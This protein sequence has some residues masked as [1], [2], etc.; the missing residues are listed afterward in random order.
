MSQDRER[1]AILPGRHEELQRLANE[2]AALRRVATLV[3]HE[4]PPAEVFAAVTEE[5]GRLLAV[6]VTTMHRYHDGAA[7]VVASWG[8]RG[9]VLTVGERIPVEGENVTAIVHRT[10]APARIDDYARATGELGQIVRNRG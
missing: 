9:G 1:V 8:E 3:A 7:T 4:S 2:Q 10:C 6:E 5:V